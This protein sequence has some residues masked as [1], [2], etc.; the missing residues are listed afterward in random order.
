MIIILIY[1]KEIIN[2]QYKPIKI[3][4]GINNICNNPIIYK[5]KK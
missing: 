3:T 5:I 2:S 1:L 4:L